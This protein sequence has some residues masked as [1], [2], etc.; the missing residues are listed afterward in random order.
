MRT[1]TTSNGVTTKIQ[2]RL[3]IF[4][5]E[6]KSNKP[7]NDVNMAPVDDAIICCSGPIVDDV[8][9]CIVESFS[10]AAILFL[11]INKIA[12]NFNPKVNNLSSYLYKKTISRKST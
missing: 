3:L 11:R 9:G 1:F 10:S 2:K 6:N 5:L 12:S 7:N 8:D 4:R